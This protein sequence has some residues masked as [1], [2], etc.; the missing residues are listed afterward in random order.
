MLI[1]AD[2]SPLNILIRIEYV[3]ILPKLFG[4]VC[5]PPEVQAELS[6]LRTPDTVRTFIANPPAWLEVRT[7]AR[8][9]PIPPLHRGEEAAISLARDSRPT[10]F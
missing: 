9:E 2:S 6:E 4:A 10:P 5:I 3:E 1:V 7:P 8:V